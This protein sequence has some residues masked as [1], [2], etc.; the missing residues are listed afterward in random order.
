MSA[1][2]VP[3]KA[4]GGGVLSRTFWS[5]AGMGIQGVA[6][7]AYTVVIGRLA[8]PETL[9]E[10]TAILSLA[11]YA[12]LFWPAAAGISASRFLTSPSQAA[13]A[14]YVLKRTFGYSL[15]ILTPVFCT[16]AWFTGS[17]LANTLGCAALIITYS[18]YVLV[19][20]VLMGEDRIKRSAVMDGIASV[21]AI[22][23]L[24]LVLVADWHWA[25]LLPLATSYALFTVLSWPR[26]QEPADPA[27]RREVM[28]FTRDTVIAIIATGGLLPATMVFVRAHED[29]LTAGL[30]AAA[31]SLATPANQISQAVNQVM[32][33]YFSRM[34]TQSL[35][36]TY[37][38]QK[39]VFLVTTGGFA[40]IFGI[41][42]LLAPWILVLTY[43]EEFR[44]GS[45]SMRAL[46]LVVFLLSAM[47]VPSAYLVAMG[48]QRENARIWLI[49]FIL[50]FVTM[51][52]TSPIWGMW[53][54]LLG[55][56]VGG[57]GG[58]LIV[59]AAG[60]LVREKSLPTPQVILQ[61]D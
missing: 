50:G 21:T 54:A 11:V 52:I 5:T 9:G 14:M 12:S 35:A 36:A 46:I 18:G 26:L 10:V 2:V 20:G 32:I 40:I 57:G 45:L 15:L 30:F 24:I 49:A 53:G 59:I 56:A 31:L 1:N 39:R 41:L 34:R 13:P 8:G 28:Q 16:I 55:F 19:R 22:T 42:A 58:S 25:T 51:A 6:R 37:A 17:N 60:L 23:A 38:L 44:D 48:R 33:P 43:G 61:E 27:L 4:H 29:P 47:S 3:E 7:F